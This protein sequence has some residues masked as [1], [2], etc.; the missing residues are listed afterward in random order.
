MSSRKL[1][2]I[3]T[4]LTTLGVT[5]STSLPAAAEPVTLFTAEDFYIPRPVEASDQ[6]GVRRLLIEFDLAANGFADIIGQECFF[7]V[8]AVNGESV[9]EN[10]YGVIQTI[11]GG[12]TLEATITG[13]ESEPNVETTVLSDDTLVVGPTITL[14]NVMEPTGDGIIGT[15]VDYS[16]VADCPEPETTTTTASTTTTTEPTTTTTAPTTTT[17]APTTTT[18][19]QVSTTSS[20]LGVT[21]STIPPVSATTLPLTGPPVETAGLAMMAMALLLLGSAALMAARER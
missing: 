19:A 14:Y 1:F 20:V 3:L 6:A 21:T 18:S 8:A 17:T 4:A 16:V 12:E 2:M 9:H 5:F 15:S 10:N 11:V 7:S 13:T